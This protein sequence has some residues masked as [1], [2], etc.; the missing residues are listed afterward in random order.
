[1][2]M[3]YGG[4]PRN[5]VR[6]SRMTTWPALVGCKQPTALWLRIKLRKYINDIKRTGRLHELAT[7]SARD[8][9]TRKVSSRMRTLFWYAVP[10]AIFALTSIQHL[11]CHFMLLPMLSISL[12]PSECKLKPK[13]FTGQFLGRS[14]QQKQRLSL[15]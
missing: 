8:S 11:P 2:K 5:R 10:T 9:T 13:G 7:S 15:E 12:F 6:W 4:P 3:F 1:M 14:V